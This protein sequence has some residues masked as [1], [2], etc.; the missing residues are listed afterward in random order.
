MTITVGTDTY[1]T[2]LEAD[3]YMEDFYL[4]NDEQR[5]IWSGLS[6]SDKEVHLRNATK[7]LERLRWIGQKY[8]TDQALFFPRITANPLPNRRNG[9]F[10]EDQELQTFSPETPTVPDAIKYAEIEE[11]LEMASPSIS[12]DNFEDVN[13]TLKSERIGDH[14]TTYRDSVSSGT[15]AII[16]SKKARDYIAPLMS[17]SYRTI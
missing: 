11:A 12:T 9:D 2:I 16:K 8:D 3:A 6:D 15:G 4:S 1:A 7:S 5:A 17:G 13:S 14:S 10:S